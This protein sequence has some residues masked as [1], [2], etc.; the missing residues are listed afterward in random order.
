MSGNADES[1]PI[2]RISHLYSK[3]LNEMQSRMVASQRQLSIVR[4]QM[5]NCEREAKLQD[6]T[7][8]QLHGLGSETRVYRAVGKMYA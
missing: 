3:I 1:L 7:M 6:L 4:A 2:V 8:E 5:R